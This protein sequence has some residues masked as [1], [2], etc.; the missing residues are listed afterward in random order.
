MASPPRDGV[1]IDPLERWDSWVDTAIREAGE[2]GEFD[3]L[4]GRGQ[5]LRLDD[6]PFAGDRALG[7][8][9]LKN[10]GVLPYW[11]ELEKEIGAD[12]AALRE[13]RERS[14]RYLSAR[15]ASTSSGDLGSGPG[16]GGARARRWPAALARWLFG[17]HRSGGGR[18]DD[19]HQ[20]D[21]AALA[22]ERRRARRA[23]LERAARLDETI[24]LYNAALPDDLRWRERPRL[25]HDQAVREFDAAC[26]PVDG[27]PPP[28][29]PGTGRPGGA[30]DGTGG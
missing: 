24:R 26:P 6:N 21:P 9:V 12:L 16:R 3:D 15:V 14:G 28:N 22:V 18:A 27:V 4:P 17:L 2:R 20:P 11:M 30:G 7:F 13:L 8:R 23:Y 5:P 19:R 10:A 25:P 29:P 1:E